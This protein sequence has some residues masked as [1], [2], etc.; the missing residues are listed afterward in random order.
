[1]TLFE[2]GWNLMAKQPQR[3]LVYMFFLDQEMLKDL[4]MK[5]TEIMFELEHKKITDKCMSCFIEGKHSQILI[6]NFC[7]KVE[8]KKSKQEIQKLQLAI[9]NQHKTKSTPSASD[10]AM[11]ITSNCKDGNLGESQN[12][13]LAL[14]FKNDGNNLFK[15]KRYKEALNAYTNGFKCRSS[16]NLVNVQLLTNRAAAHFHLEEYESSL[17]VCKLATKKKPDHFKACKRAAMCCY[18]LKKFPECVEWAEKSLMLDI[19]DQEMQELLLKAKS[20]ISAGKED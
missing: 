5:S 1:M 19:S 2:F 17:K 7:K 15:Q 9:L 4:I 8:C 12:H 6:P 3:L 18:E 10:A 16:D 14:K 13:K 11:K 20:E